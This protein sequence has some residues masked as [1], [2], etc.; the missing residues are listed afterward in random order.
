MKRHLVVYS[1]AGLS[2]ESGVPTFRTDNGLWENHKIEDVATPAGWKRNPDFVLKFYSDRLDSVRNAQ[3]N[4][5][6]KVLAKLE[7][8]FDVT[9][10]TQNID[11]LLERAG[12]TN[13]IHL[14][15]SLFKRSCQ[16]RNCIYE[17]DQT[18]AIRLGDLCPMCNSQIRPSV[19]WF[20]EAVDMQRGKLKSLAWKSRSDGIFLVVGTSLKVYP[21]ASIVDIFRSLKTKYI[22][23]PSPIPLD[24]FKVLA[25]KAGDILPKL[26][27][28]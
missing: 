13:V 28:A 1:G 2:A 23:D 3:P 21:A 7:N 8:D 5:A 16:Q 10:I 15:G 4:A 11:D 18:E 12:A 20:G 22:I 24:G 26:F 17:E 9:H 27:H 25:G 14:H 19:V 6:H